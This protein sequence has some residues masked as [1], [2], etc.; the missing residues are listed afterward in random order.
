MK[1]TTSKI[2]KFKN[3]D[4]EFDFWSSRD[5]TDLFSDTEEVSDQLEIKKPKRKKQRITILLDPQLKMQ[6]QKL[7]EEKGIPYQTLIQMWLKDRV[8]EEIRSKIAS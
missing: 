3:E 4:E 2:P 5:S 8:R 7:A 6:L 1:K